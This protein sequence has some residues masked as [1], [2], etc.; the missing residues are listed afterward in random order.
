[1]EMLFIGPVQT[2][3]EEGLS[4]SSKGQSPRT[5][6]TNAPKLEPLMTCLSL[7]LMGSRPQRKEL[8]SAKGPLISAEGKPNDFAL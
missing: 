5:L 7:G 3:G 8:I 2:H 1:M 6:L 4:D